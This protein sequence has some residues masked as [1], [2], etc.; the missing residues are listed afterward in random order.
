[1]GAAD[2]QQAG[3]EAKG[4]VSGPLFTWTFTRA[5]VLEMYSRGN[6]Y[7]YNLLRQDAFTFFFLEKGLKL[8]K[9]QA[10]QDP[11]FVPAPDHKYSDSLPLGVDRILGDYLCLFSLF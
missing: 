3:L 10:L 9:S 1:M 11:E 7:L 5:W 2:P 6:R 8:F 4:D